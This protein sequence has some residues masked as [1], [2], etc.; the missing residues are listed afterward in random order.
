LAFSVKLAVCLGI[1]TLWAVFC[2][3][4]GN[5]AEAVYMAITELAAHPLAT[6]TKAQLSKAS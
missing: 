4:A 1:E 3:Y 6:V 2:V 5:A